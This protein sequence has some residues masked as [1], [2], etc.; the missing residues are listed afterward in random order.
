MSNNLGDL[1]KGD[2]TSAAVYKKEEDMQYVAVKE[3]EFNKDVKIE[4]GD[5]VQIQ[6]GKKWETVKETVSVK[7]KRGRK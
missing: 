4:K 1:I 3:M 6:K 5:I 2:V 7:K